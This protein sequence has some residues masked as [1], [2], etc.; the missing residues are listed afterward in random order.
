LCLTLASRTPWDSF[1]N[2]L[3]IS[4]LKSSSFKWGAGGGAGVVYGSEE[5]NWKD[6]CL[7]FWK[8]ILPVSL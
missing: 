4:R 2:I 1:S 6:F 7:K 8:N 3:G 5:T